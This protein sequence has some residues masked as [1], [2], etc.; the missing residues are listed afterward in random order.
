MRKSV[1][2]LAVLAVLVVTVVSTGCV[3]ES[4]YGPMIPLTVYSKYTAP[5]G[6]S[7]YMRVCTNLGTYRVYGPDGVTS[8]QDDANAYSTMPINRTIYVRLAGDRLWWDY[9]CRVPGCNSPVVSLCC[10]DQATPTP[11]PVPLPPQCS[12]GC[13]TCGCGC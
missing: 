7:T 9:D 6:F 8:H 2:V 4:E 12:C 11:T 10:C 3:A 13:R 5:N 1:M